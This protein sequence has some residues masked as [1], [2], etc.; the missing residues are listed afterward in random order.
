MPNSSITAN[1]QG[2]VSFVG[3][4]PGDPG[5]LTLK[6]ADLIREAQVIMT[7]APDHEALV[8]GLNTSAE[9]IDGA[10]GGALDLA[11]ARRP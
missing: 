4:G 1:P 10:F 7:D 8:A 6:A 5:L 3:T 9:L 11:Q 2:W